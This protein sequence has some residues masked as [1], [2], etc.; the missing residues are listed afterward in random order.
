MPRT[1]LRSRAPL[2]RDRIIGWP[3]QKGERQS[4]KTACNYSL[5]IPERP[6]PTAQLLYNSN[7]Q[8][9]EYLAEEAPGGVPATPR[10]HRFHVVWYYGGFAPTAQPIFTC[11]HASG[12]QAVPPGLIDEVIWRGG[13]VFDRTTLLLRGVAASRRP[14][15]ANTTYVL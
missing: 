14:H 5:V 8:F 9:I 13:F 12:A 15:R 4:R 6:D 7:R 2:R 10:A 1:E 3:T 11:T